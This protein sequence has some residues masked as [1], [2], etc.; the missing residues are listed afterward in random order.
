MQVVINV[1]SKQRFLGRAT[2][3]GRFLLRGTDAIS[4]LFSV[5]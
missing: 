3:R 4:G 2:G 1:F 5:L